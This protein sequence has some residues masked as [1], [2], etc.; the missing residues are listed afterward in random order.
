M[1]KKC[2]TL[3][4][5]QPSQSKIR[6][7]SVPHSI[8]YSL[9][10]ATFVGIFTLVIFL[11]NFT[12]MAI[13][14]GEFNHI[15]SE[16]QSLRI[17]NQKYLFSTAE[18]VQ[19]ISFLEVL[20]HKLVVVAG[21]EK[22]PHQAISPEKER[23]AYLITD[24]ETMP[25]GSGESSAE[26][27]QRLSASVSQLELR[28]L[29]L[30]S[31]FN[32]RYF[33]LTLTPNIW[34]VFGF[35]SDR[36]GRR[37]NFSELGESPFHAGIDIA[38]GYGNRVLASADGTVITADQLTGYGNIVVIDH[39]FGISTRYAHLSAFNVQLGQRVKR[40]QIVGFVG[41]TGRSTGP[42]LH[43]EVRVDGKPVN[44]LR[45]IPRNS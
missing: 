36:F 3:I 20:T 17:E 41:A 10:F 16:I 34:P 33:K 9:G 30:E 12:R 4:I 19:K 13:K 44:P 40:G 24:L 28:V 31:Y 29:H 8:V 26:P 37:E 2:F 14:V 38:S 32:D 25:A 21:L 23:D 27:L 1:A 45:Y 7:I 5:A 43:Y 11:V 39:G 18:L 35:L 6:K 42:H 22:G 15:R